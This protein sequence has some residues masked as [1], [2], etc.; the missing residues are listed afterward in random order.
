MQ[1]Q[2]HFVSN[3]GNLHL[4]VPSRSV[5][6]LTSQA[7]TTSH[8]DDIQLDYEYH[9][10]ELESWSERKSEFS[11]SYKTQSRLASRNGALVLV[12]AQPNPTTK[13]FS[14]GFSS[15]MSL[16]VEVRLG[17]YHH[18]L[19]SENLP[20]LCSSGRFRVLAEEL[21]DSDLKIHPQ[22]LQTCKRVN[23]EATEI[24][25]AANVF[26]RRFYWPVTYGRRGR[27]KHLPLKESSPISA[28]NLDSITKIRLFRE[29][30][31]WLRNGR[32]RV[33]DEFPRL[34]E[35]QIHMDMNYAE[36]SSS[37]LKETLLAI[38]RHHRHLPSLTVKLRL[39]FNQAWK[40]WCNEY[41]NKPMGFSLHMRKM[42]ELQDWMTSAGNIF[43]GRQ[44][45]W[46]FLI[47]L[48]PHC[49][50]S[51][52]VIFSTGLFGAEE[53]HV[54]CC[55]DIDGK[56]TFSKMPTKCDRSDLI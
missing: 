28:A 35:L 52:T 30:N 36:N 39:P 29:H 31:A 3:H 6:E 44:T 22:I 4:Y 1:H 43:T 25:Y 2:S 51:A 27:S 7:W 41:T 20:V 10:P 17:I 5:P 45:N 40:D 15:F 12:H 46:T 54:S 14:S 33:L 42:Q 24:L 32:L 49:G 53:A 38:H 50:P 48:A 18:L 56:K 26:R 8:L 23:A 37:A 11:R 19:V 34:R 16:P 13:N 9:S 55:I 47:N 21:Y